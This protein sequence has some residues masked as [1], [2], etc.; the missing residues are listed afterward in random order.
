MRYNFTITAGFLLLSGLAS[1]AV[2]P[3]KAD[4]LLADFGHGL[5]FVVGRSAIAENSLRIAAPPT[6]PVTV[7]FDDDVEG[8]P[9]TVPVFMQDEWIFDMQDVVTWANFAGTIID[10]SLSEAEELEKQ[11][12]AA[13]TGIPFKIRDPRMLI[14]EGSIRISGFAILDG[15]RITCDRGGITLTNSKDS[16]RVF[17]DIF[18]VSWSSASECSIDGQRFVRRG[19]SWAAESARMPSSAPRATEEPSGREADMH[20]IA[21]VRGLANLRS[22]VVGQTSFAT[23][24]ADFGNY[25]TRSASHDPA[26]V[27][28]YVLKPLH[29]EKYINAPSDKLALH[30]QGLDELRVADELT[31]FVS[32]VFVLGFLRPDAATSVEPLTYPQSPDSFHVIA[33]LAFKDGSLALIELADI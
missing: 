9:E 29:F 10:G 1:A 15:H 30:A 5:Q 22:Y 14:S 31:Q 6:H 7:E 21:D 17:D 11:Q 32:G 4:R 27:P 28:G 8:T 19:S 18:D 16:N 25:F 23:F 26:S 12:H 3:A 24:Q 33:V 13:A 2:P 20:E